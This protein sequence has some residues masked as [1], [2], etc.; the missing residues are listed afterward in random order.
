[1]TTFSKD[2]NFIS[3]NDKGNLSYF[4]DRKELDSYRRQH[5]N[6]QMPCVNL[7][8]SLFTYPIKVIEIGSGYSSLLYALRDNLRLKIGVGID[9]SETSYNFAEKWKEDWDYNQIINLHGNALEIPFLKNT[10][11]IIAIDNVFTFLYPEDSTYPTLFLEK[12]YKSLR[13]EGKL[14]LEMSNYYPLTQKLV[15]NYWNTLPSTDIFKYGLHENIFHW[16][17]NIVEA[18]SI[19]ISK[20]GIISEK[21]DISW[22]YRV[23]DIKLLLHKNGFKIV[24]IMSTFSGEVY[25]ETTSVKLIILAEKV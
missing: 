13:C 1:M 18:K 15:A 8:K 22:F 7:L 5:I 20:D 16:K 14:L 17:E 19:F 21:T 4:K 24:N 11:I 2:A 3:Y 25:D 9:V 12:T 10:D 6:K 23:S